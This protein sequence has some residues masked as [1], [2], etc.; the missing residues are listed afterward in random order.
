[1]SKRKRSASDHYLHDDSTTS[2][3]NPF[4]KFVQQSNDI[5]LQEDPSIRKN[6]QDE[7]FPM[8]VSFLE[9]T[10]KRKGRN[11]KSSRL[12]DENVSSLEADDTRIARQLVET[13]NKETTAMNLPLHRR[14]I[15]ST[16]D[17][18][19][20]LLP[21]AIKRLLYANGS[22]S[23]D[24]TSEMELE[25]EILSKC[26]DLVLV[27]QQQHTGMH[28]NNGKKSMGHELS[29]HFSLSAL[30]KLV[31]L[32]GSVAWGEVS[33]ENG[34]T[35]TSCR[36]M[37][38]T[39]YCAWVQDLYRPP[40]DTVCETLLP[41]V[42]ED[43]RRRL[44]SLCSGTSSIQATPILSADGNH[45]PNM[46]TATLLLLQESLKKANPKRAFQ[47]LTRCHT[48]SA[49]SDIY[50]SNPSDENIQSLIRSLLDD[51]LYHLDHHMDGF[52]S[53]Q[54]VLPDLGGTDDKNDTD[55]IE[56]EVDTPTKKSFH[57]YQES[58]PTMIEEAFSFSGAST[59]EKER[60]GLASMNSIGRIVPLLLDGFVKQSNDIQHHKSKGK[61]SA[62][63]QKIAMKKILQLQ[64][65][66]F[67]HL[68]APMIGATNR[69]DPTKHGTS[70]EIIL[71][72][73]GQCVHSLLKHDV[74]L[75]ANDDADDK[76]FSYLQ[77][78]SQMLV[79]YA[80]SP[81]GADSGISMRVLPILASTLQLNHLIFHAN[82]SRTISSCLTLTRSAT[83]VPEEAIGF[84]C[85]VIST[86]KRLRQLDYLCA[87]LVE[88]TSYLRDQDDVNGL[89]ALFQLVE[90]SKVIDQFGEAVQSSPI[91]Q[92]KQ[93]VSNF[94]E[95]ILQ[96]A[97]PTS[98]T[99]EQNGARNAS[100]ALVVS[101]FCLLLKTTRID[102][103]S[104]SDLSPLC[105]EIGSSIQAL[106]G[107]TASLESVDFL[108]K[109]GLQLCGWTIDLKN[110]CDFWLRNSREEETHHDFA[111]P[112]AVSA[113][114][115]EAVEEV[116]EGAEN[117]GGNALEELQLLACHR[118][119][120]LHGN[121][122]EKQR[123]A[124][125]TE[126]EEFGFAIDVKETKQIATF[127]L[128]ALQLEKDEGSV[129][130]RQWNLLIRS[131]PS[132]AP[133]V[134]DTDM[135]WFLSRFFLRVCATRASDRNEDPTLWLLRDAS[136]LET[137]NVLK[138]FA[139]SGVS[140]VARAVQ[141][142]FHGESAKHSRR[143]HEHAC[144]P[145]SD[146]WKPL[147]P[148]ELNEV[149]EQRL[150]PTSTGRNRSL[151]NQVSPLQ[152]ALECVQLLNN[153]PGSIWGFC[154]FPADTLFES[155]LRLDYVCRD[156]ARQKGSSQP[157]A[158]EVVASLRKMLATILKDAGPSPNILAQSSRILSG[159]FL[160]TR[161]MMNFVYVPLDLRR[162]VLDCTK[163]A[164]A[165][166]LSY[167]RGAGL[168]SDISLVIKKHYQDDCSSVS[169]SEALI[170]ISFGLSIVSGL[171]RVAGP[172]D[173]DGA[174]SI[175]EGICESVWNTAI[176]LA[177][178]TKETD[179]TS[180]RTAVHFISEVLRSDC[181]D[182]AKVQDR[183]MSIEAPLIE[184]IDQSIHYEVSTGELQ[185]TAYVIASYA[186]AKPPKESRQ[187]L[188]D[189]LTMKPG[190]MLPSIIQDALCQLTIEMESD[191]LREC[192]VKLTSA[193]HASQSLCSRLR[194]LRLIILNAKSEDQIQVISKS[195]RR[196]LSLSLGAMI[197]NGKY[198]NGIHDGVELI[199]EMASS[200]QIISIRER[201]LCLI[202]AHVVGAMQTEEGQL[203]VSNEIFNSC[204][205]VV[206]FV[207]QRFSKQLHNCIPSV[208]SCMTV[209][210]EHS[211]YADLPDLEII[212][213][214]QKVSRLCELLLPHGE[215]Y[216]KHV[217]C[218]VVEFVEALK[219]NMDPTRRH[220]LSPG[221]YCLLD[222]LQ[223]HETTQL[224]AMLD[225]MGRALLRTVHESY[226]KQHV[227]K[228][229]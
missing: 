6:D 118:L 170:L 65:L 212:D 57:C 15:I 171:S 19:S 174:T 229:Q 40:F 61:E 26:T 11:L 110:R 93:V 91:H 28:S 197:S 205:S 44:A 207:L 3:C 147:S 8:V 5:A 136:F 101:V 33:K 143:L 7:V 35:S 178:S 34:A 189:V 25:W 132:W 58:L 166:L 27:S 96:S 175:I 195:S 51:G 37:A 85:T 227:Y 214:G 59:I 213:R 67:A 43:A 106:M 142:M 228:G 122:H 198:T 86:Y 114:L 225:D 192:L 124:F 69:L 62:G 115:A 18:A 154:G 47:S 172:G 54:I 56:V 196:F 126:A 186:A 66:F 79:R 92:I 187:S 141:E 99:S 184:K 90:N 160:S 39:C 109:R 23:N 60:E 203:S 12:P 84:F 194:L 24:K 125:A 17:V 16:E 140:F 180:R 206:S 123:V 2:S 145:E 42:G 204:F 169:Q 95:W 81:R 72:S 199:Q 120:Q 10:R 107:T 156:I 226:K 153:V 98:W 201:D 191:E 45:H 31:P 103:S 215:V 74:Y 146:G 152:N 127:A 70:V 30:H 224:N 76:N 219:R 168:L 173:T 68:T 202:L 63:K 181:V 211:L 77:S 182:P 78:V 133:Y 48:V 9:L 208:V 216:K 144:P 21:W 137:P 155:C 73:L 200:R 50:S 1:M 82:L 223:Q 80:S 55:A 116:V 159:L 49:L 119:Q 210:L 151:G 163:E 185:Y 138:N 29:N 20:L 221:I 218:L 165:Q 112:D 135:R 164:V 94:N 104:G 46:A 121:I 111:I 148:S 38:A 157:A 88:A 188:F 150:E 176:S 193:E 52:R 167:A 222:I 183:L 209:I 64:F 100:I 220:A 53:L 36:Q 117:K 217:L 4:L 139:L 190:I 161:D 83:E 134:E 75:P 177:L 108:A 129:F 71:Q 41:L 97:V 102:A 131:L 158:F 179:K 162:N 22:S 128:K 87:S 130:N 113:V 32:A 149:L 89:H 13:L 105:L 14:R